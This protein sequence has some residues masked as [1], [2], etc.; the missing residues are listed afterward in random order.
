MGEKAAQ[1]GGV[2]SF[3]LPGVHPHD[4]AQVLDQNGI[5]IR[6]G[7][8]CAMPL[9]D[10]FGIPASSRASFYLYNTE[11]EVDHLVKSLIE[12]IEMFS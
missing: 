11:K 7:H 8:H 9:H 4:V 2:I 10:K 1:R 6:A 5:A 12:V 3:T